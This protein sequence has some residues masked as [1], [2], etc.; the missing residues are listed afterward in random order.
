ME[1]MNIIMVCSAYQNNFD[2]RPDKWK[3]QN[4]AAYGTMS[5]DDLKKLMFERLPEAFL[6]ALQ[7]LYGDA[8]VVEGVDVIY[9]INFG[10][11]DGS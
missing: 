10:I 5:D 9:T 2:F 7:S 11:Y 8:D 3:V 6:P 4:P 1:I